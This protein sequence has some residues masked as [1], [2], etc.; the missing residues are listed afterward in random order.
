MKA[1]LQ[2]SLHWEGSLRPLK[3]LLK[4]YKEDESILYLCSMISHLA[5]QNKLSLEERDKLFSFIEETKTLAGRQYSTLLLP[6][7]NKPE[8]LPLRRAFQREFRMCLLRK[9][10]RD[11]WIDLVWYVRTIIRLW[12]KYK[13]PPQLLND[14]LYPT[15]KSI[16][17]AD[18]HATCYHQFPHDFR[19]ASMARAIHNC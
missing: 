8:M 6:P 2:G 7:T 4:E 13:F 12:D 17:P 5:R 14:A 1:A 3:T 18:W 15:L 16:S 9:L 19:L 10:I 11:R